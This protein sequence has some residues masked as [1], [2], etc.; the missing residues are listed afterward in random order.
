MTT[1]RNYRYY[2]QECDNAIC[3]ELL[4]ADKCIVKMFC[5]SG[6]SLVM[7]N[8]KITQNKNLVTYVFPSLSLI[9]QFSNDYLGDHNGLILKISSELGSTTDSIMIKNFL[10]SKGDKIILVTYQSFDTLLNNLEDTKINVCIFDEAHH[11]VGET[12]QQLIFGNTSCEKQIFFTATPKNANGITMY[13]LENDKVGDCGNLVYDYSY[14]KGMTE[15]YLNPFEIRIDMYGENTNYSIYESIVR[16]IMVSGN[17]RVLTFHSDVNTDRDTSVNKFVNLEE[18]KK[19]YKKVIENEFP[20]KKKFYGKVSFKA[21]DSSIKPT[22]RKK[23]LDDFDRTLDNDIYVISSCETIGEG[24]DTKNSNMVVF[25]DPKTSHVKI[26]QNIGR[27]VRKQFGVDKKPSTV[28]LPCWVDKTKYLECNGDRE[29]CD[30]V[31]RKDMN[32]TGNFSIIMNVMAALKQEDNDLYELCVNYGNSYSPREIKDN[33]KKHGYKVV[34]TEENS[35]LFEILGNVLDVE[36]EEEIYEDMPTDDIIIAIADGNDVCVEVHSD[37]LEKPVRK[38]FESN[39]DIVRILE[40][41]ELNDDGDEEISYNIIVKNDETKR[42]RDVI[43]GISRNRCRLDVNVG[44]DI[45][46]LWNVTGELDITKEICN[47][48]INCNVEDRWCINCLDVIN[49]VRKNGCRP[50]QHSNDP[51]IRRLGYWISDA[52][53]RNKTRPIKDESKKI[54][55]NELMKLDCM[56]DSIELWIN[57]RNSVIEYIKTNN[58]KPSCSDENPNV[59]S[60]GLWISTQY[61]NLKQNS[62]TMTDL[63]KRELFM[64]LI[65]QYDCMKIRN[66]DALW[67]SMHDCVSEYID[68]NVKSPCRRDKNIYIRKLGNWVELQFENLKKNTGAMSDSKKRELFLK[69]I[70]KYKC[71]TL[72]NVYDKW[73]NKRNNVIKYIEDNKKRP[74]PGDKDPYIRSLGYW[75]ST[76][77]KNLENNIGSMTDPIMRDLFIELINKY[78]CMKMKDFNQVWYNKYYATCKYSNIH[79]HKPSYNDTNET[80]ANLGRW[81]ST[82]S[83]NLDKGIEAM[84]DPQKAMLFKELQNNNFAFAPVYDDQA[85]YNLSHSNTEF[86]NEITNVAIIPAPKVKLAKSITSSKKSMKLTRTAK[87]E[88][89]NEEIAKERKEKIKSEL[90]ELHKKY[91]T[92]NSKNLHNEFNN[93]QKIW[94]EY[95]RIA[96]DNEKS[97]P[98]DEIPRNL[99]I[100]ELDAIK[101][102]R[103]K[104][105]VDMGCGKADIS[106]RFKD[107]KRFQFINFDHIACDETVIARDISNTELDSNSFDVAILSLAMWGSNCKDYIKE[108]YRILESGG[109]LYIIEPTKRWSEK[110]GMYSIIEGSEGIHLKNLLKDNNFQISYEKID[111]FCMFRCIKI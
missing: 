11:A 72:R 7:R 38:Y 26:I 87:K 82:Q 68:V 19:A 107:D 6:K 64:N 4:T 78:E 27:I 79:G 65:N 103:K 36:I 60:L 93:N 77:Y 97:F 55:W 33:L 44:D 21:L 61:K 52:I 83:S 67:M 56:G 66:S 54:L 85:I 58:I 37:S 14:Y 34:E 70:S 48:A 5:G 16:S 2:Q 91:K 32:K 86:T 31:I 59:R 45:K 53:A 29:K 98:D 80:I 96:E 18:F 24:I 23:I 101:T 50:S 62:L 25:V 20:D 13:D 49:F 90:S 92:M 41:K 51:N 84:A 17:N 108:A 42:N 105:V 106:K 1:N 71:L 95:H 35:G 9:E 22:M 104:I 69:L 8:C 81:I 30:E 88:I 100:K 40:K 46:I 102:K 74:T 111:K 109:W 89:S 75:I 43:G 73:M 94:F 57:K 10:K 3:K 63:M 39:K 12:Y 110:E 99:I 76:Q 15:G 47:C 28:L